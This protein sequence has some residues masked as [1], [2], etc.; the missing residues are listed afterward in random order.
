MKYLVAL[1]ISFITINLNLSAQTLGADGFKFSGM[2]EDSVFC[3]L[4]TTMARASVKIIVDC[5]VG[6]LEL[7]SIS[8]PRLRL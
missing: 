4:L 2:G 7:E 1:I 3:T 6:N 8:Y 5:N